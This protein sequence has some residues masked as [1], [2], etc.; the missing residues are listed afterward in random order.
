MVLYRAS[1]V[2]CSVAM[3][4]LVCFNGVLSCFYVVPT[5]FLLCVL[6]LFLRFLVFLC[7]LCV[8]STVFCKFLRCLQDF[9]GVSTVPTETS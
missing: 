2:F 3:V 9:Y 5:V 6:S 8:V 1:M 7:C 4:V